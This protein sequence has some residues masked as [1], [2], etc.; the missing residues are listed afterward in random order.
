SVQT[1]SRGSWRYLHLLGSLGPCVAALVVTAWTGGRTRLRELARGMLTTPAARVALIWGVLFPSAT[2]F[3]SA[4]VMSLLNH[5]QLHWNRLGVV[6][7][8]PTLSPVEYIVASF[9]FYGI[10]EEV[11]WR[12]V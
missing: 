4:E 10:G 9:V 11:G 1:G 2:F 7:E 12:G 8:F 6:P 5:A 3:V